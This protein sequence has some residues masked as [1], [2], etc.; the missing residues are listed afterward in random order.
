M[1]FTM[2]AIECSRMPK[3]KFLPP[4]VAASKLPA[5]ADVRLKDPKDFTL[6]GHP[7]NRLDTP[8][9]TDGSAQYAIDVRLP[10]L[11]TAVIARPPR[12]GGVVKSF[13]AK[14]ALAIGGVK[15]VFAVPTGIAVVAEGY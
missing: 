10:G 1:P 14:E 7:D 8:A 13:D 5:P 15:N 11:L 12:F 6:I 3:W 4:G 9:K 2:A